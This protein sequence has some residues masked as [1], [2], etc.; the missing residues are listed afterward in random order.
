MYQVEQ[1]K[2]FTPWRKDVKFYSFAKE[3][4]ISPLIS[5]FKF[6]PNKEKWGAAFRYGFL[7]IQKE[8]FELI[9]ASMGADS[10]AKSKEMETPKAEISV[11]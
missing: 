4:P 2:G 3:A 11:L 7:Q 6:I 10:G 5:K 8:D 1:F 9:Y